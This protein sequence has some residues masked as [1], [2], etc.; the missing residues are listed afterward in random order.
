MHSGNNVRSIRLSLHIEAKD[1][2]KKLKINKHTLEQIEASENMR[3]H[4]LARIAA[5]L[6]VSMQDIENY[7]AES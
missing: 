4:A 5:A 3:P 6:G 7:Q 2:A 1:L